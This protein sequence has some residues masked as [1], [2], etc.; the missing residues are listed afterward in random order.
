MKIGDTFKEQFISN[1]KDKLKDR[2]TNNA[3]LQQSAIRR[4]HLHYQKI[5]LGKKQGRIGNMLKLLHQ[6]HD[7]YYLGHY[8]ATCMLAGS[9]LEKAFMYKAELEIESG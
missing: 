6:L 1:S 3:V 5:T 9:L 7:N 4:W 2:W 8:E